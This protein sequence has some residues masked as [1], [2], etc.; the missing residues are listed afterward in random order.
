MQVK[1]QKLFGGKKLVKKE[2]KFLLCTDEKDREVYL[3]VE[4]RGTFY[5]LTT[6]GHGT[7]KIP[8]MRM[9][10]IC[11]RFRF[12]C[13]VKLLFGRVPSTPCSFT[14]TL[15][16]QDS[17]MESSVIGCTMLNLRN[18]LLDLPIDSDLRF[19]M[20][21]NT[22]E[23]L[24]SK[25]YKNA[26]AL[27]QDKATTYMRNM[28]VAYYIVSDDDNAD[29]PLAAVEQERASGDEVSGSP[30]TERANSVSNISRS[31]TAMSRPRPSIVEDQ[32]LFRPPETT[33]KSPAKSPKISSQKYSSKK[34]TQRAET[35]PIADPASSTLTSDSPTVLRKD[36]TFYL[37]EPREVLLVRPPKSSPSLSPGNRPLSPLVAPV[38]P[39]DTLANGHYM[40]MG[41]TGDKWTVPRGQGSLGRGSKKPPPTPPK[42]IV[43]RPPTH[44]DSDTF[45]YTQVWDGG[46]K[47]SPAAKQ[48]QEASEGKPASPEPAVHRMSSI[49]FADT[50]LTLPLFTEA[51]KTT[52]EPTNPAVGSDGPSATHGHYRAPSSLPVSDTV[53]PGA[54]SAADQPYETM[55]SVSKPICGTEG[56]T[57]SKRNAPKVLP[58]PKPHSSL[59]RSPDVGVPR[60][61]PLPPLPTADP[62]SISAPPIR[63]ENTL[64]TFSDTSSIQSPEHA[65]RLLSNTST[66]QRPRVCSS[67]RDFDQPYIGMR[68]PSFIYY[69]GYDPA[70]DEQRV[71]KIKASDSGVMSD[72]ELSDI[73]VSLADYEN[74]ENLRLY[75]GRSKASASDSDSSS[76]QGSERHGRFLD[77]VANPATMLGYTS[78]PLPRPFTSKKP[79]NPANSAGDE[80]NWQGSLDSES[81]GANAVR[82]P[83]PKPCK[84]KAKVSATGYLHPFAVL[85]LSSPVASTS[86]SE[87]SE[88][89]S[90]ADYLS[91]CEAIQIT[92][93]G[94]PC[95]PNQCANVSQHPQSSPSSQDFDAASGI[96]SEDDL[97]LGA[98]FY[99]FQPPMSDSGCAFESTTG[100]RSRSAW[101]SS[102]VSALSVADLGEAL[103]SVGLMRKTVDTLRQQKVDGK[104]LVSL[105]ED[106]LI[107]TLPDVKKLDIKKIL[108]FV[109]GWRPKD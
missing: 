52:T 38:S 97:P 66:S 104:L 24:S 94:P 16:L 107:E 109:N 1:K 84:L 5:M 101:G 65:S 91:P 79:S 23:L 7:P 31:G 54:S 92:N 27:C 96:S 64:L 21:R 30:L 105:D 51:A 13:V 12:P 10:D 90:S 14:G 36:P 29:P 61:R 49:A 41:K 15:L 45:L 68:H 99:S 2:E 69:E 63:F 70:G 8:I 34:P 85:E 100:S 35:S 32:E 102:E 103:E 22:A 42:P 106:V 28:K 98:T 56:Q 37:P 40:K 6:E 71:T 108:M 50:Y 72:Q 46:I 25:C 18:I 88:I 3:P 93:T 74:V 48:S 55:S 43:S 82:P 62:D 4:S 86:S 75:T 59:S 20:A 73:H 47:I 95:G 9:P 78:P 57:A 87:A 89:T 83:P 44:T 58:K 17:Q 19:F 26:S 81:N 80:V 39:D 11:T 60:S 76:Y 67:Q 33:P 77:K 53:A